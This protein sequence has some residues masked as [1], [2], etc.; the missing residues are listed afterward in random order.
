M[1]HSEAV[2]TGAVEKYLLGEFSPA[3]ENEFTEHFFDCAE[4]AS[5]L[6][7]ASLFI[8]TAKEVLQH[9]LVWAPR[10]AK[11]WWRMEWLPL[12]YSTAVA[13]VCLALIVYQNVVVFPKLRRSSSPQTLAYVSLSNMGE[14]NVGQAGIVPPEGKPFI[15]LIDVPVHE[16]LSGYRCEI[17]TRNGSKV[18]S[19]DVSDALARRPVP[20]LIP[21]STLTRGDYVVTISGRPRDGHGPY[22]E[23]DRSPFQVM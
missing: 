12:P 3:K 4:C 15:F 18:L 2:K 7:L 6:R 8:D 23:I 14:R 19:V 11:R 13:I 22:V 20:I 21:A 10:A 1:D 17:Q 16:D 5:D 9:G